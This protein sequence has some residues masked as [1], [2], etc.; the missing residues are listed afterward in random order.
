MDQSIEPQRLTNLTIDPT[1]NHWRLAAAHERACTNDLE[2]YWVN[3][4]IY[5]RIILLSYY[6]DNNYVVYY[7]DHAI[8]PKNEKVHLQLSTWTRTKFCKQ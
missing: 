2:S 5:N 4:I 1:G 7:Y 6:D 8:G 3:Y